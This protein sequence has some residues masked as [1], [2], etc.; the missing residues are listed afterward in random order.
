MK[1]YDAIL[2]KRGHIVLAQGGDPLEYA[3]SVLRHFKVLVLCAMELQYGRHLFPGVQCIYAPMDDN[4]R[5]P[6]F[7]KTLQTAA[8]AAKEAASHFPKPTLVTCHA[9][10]NRSGL[11]TGLLL[12]VLTGEG[13]AKIVPHIRARRKYA[14]GNPLF[15][16]A[17][18]SIPPARPP[19]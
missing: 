15:V 17:L 14:L 11:V 18:L 12:H 8:R 4:H 10:L 19:L 5:D 1:P 9:G 7:T 6:H 2:S 3:P 13:G 16:E